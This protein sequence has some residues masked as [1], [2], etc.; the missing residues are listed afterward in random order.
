MKKTKIVATIGP[1][2]ENIDI[3][4][5]MIKAGMNVARLNFSHGDYAEQGAR[6]STVRQ[7]SKELNRPIAILLDTKGP[8]IRTGKFKD[9]VITIDG[10]NKKVILKEG[11]SFTFYSEDKLGDL[12]GCSVSFKDLHKAV[13]VGSN[14]KANDGLVSFTVTAINGTNVECKVDNDGYIGNNKNMN[15]PGIATSIPFLSEKDKEDIHFGMEQGMDYIAASFTRTAADI[16][17]IRDIFKAGGK[18]HIKIIAKIENHEGLD[19]LPAI[20]EAAD[21]VMVARGDL[22]VEIPQE[23][24]PV[25]QRRMIKECLSAGKIVIVATQMLQTMESNPRPTR[26]EV[27]DVANAVWLGATA[28]MLSGESAQGKY[29]VESVKTMSEIAERAE[30]SIN[31]WEEFFRGIKIKE[32]LLQSSAVGR[33]ACDL[34]ASLNAKAILVLTYSGYTAREVARFRPACPIIAETP[35]EEVKNQ[36]ALYWGVEAFVGIKQDDVKASINNAIELAVKN[37]YIALGDLII[38]TSGFPAGK[39]NHT[40]L[41]K[42]HKVGDEVL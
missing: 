6:F 34:A 35:K 7:L 26:A 8:E 17:I 19:N 14:I 21:G 22:G 10:D 28:T 27:S 40:N 16:Q 9:G 23:D 11:Q 4:R 25:A 5:E 32:P 13:K 33:A 20:I 42:V 39:T 37:G 3:M 2:S 15:L 41:I 18:E 30:K 31:Y 24:V 1:A 36:L 29:P 12:T 38:I